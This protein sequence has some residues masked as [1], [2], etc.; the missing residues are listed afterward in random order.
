MGIFSAS[1]N[2]AKNGGDVNKSS[3]LYELLVLSEW[4]ED[5][6][7]VCKSFIKP[8]IS[9]IIF[10]GSCLHSFLIFHNDTDQLGLYLQDVN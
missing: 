10:L 7:N 4:F 1:A 3:I 2:M 6:D 5:Y 8:F 9:F